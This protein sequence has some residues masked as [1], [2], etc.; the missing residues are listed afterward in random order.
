MTDTWMTKAPMLTP[1]YDAG[2]GVID[3][4][5]YV[6]GGWD[7]NS[8]SGRNEVYDPVNDTWA[9][10]TPMPTGRQ[11][12]ASGVI[13]SRLH[14]VGGWDRCNDLTIHEMYDPVADTWTTE[15]PIPIPTENAAAGVIKNI[16]YIVGGFSGY[17][18][19]TYV[20][21]GCLAT[22]EAYTGE[23]YAG[24]S[25]ILF[26]D[27]FNRPDSLTLGPPWTEGN[28][29]MALLT[30]PSGAYWKYWGPGF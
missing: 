4:K 2:A 29:T 8:A 10:G 28:E 21:P 11:V 18:R 13:N 6:I 3:G 22:L 17:S 25:E 14:I 16:L 24:P 30:L 5:F 15:A 20:G 26:Q 12:P 23:V 19:C 1:R 7:G 9:T 27:D